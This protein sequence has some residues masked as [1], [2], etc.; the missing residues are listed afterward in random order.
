MDMMQRHIMVL[1][2]THP[3]G[4]EEWLCPT[5]GRRF[6]AQWA[7]M[8]KRLILEA[9]DEAALH[10]GG[11]LQIGAQLQPGPEPDTFSTDTELDT[12]WSDWLDTLDFDGPRPDEPTS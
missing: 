12:L 11:E 9:G 7:P 5:C 10:T 4:A 6:V 2:Q 1:T 3:S 8:L